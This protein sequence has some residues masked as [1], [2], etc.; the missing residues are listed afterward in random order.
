[1]TDIV[2]PFNLNSR[3]YKNFAKKMPGMPELSPFLVKIFNSQSLIKLKVFLMVLPIISFVLAGLLSTIHYFS[4]RYSQHIE[5]WH[6]E[7]LSF[8]SGLFITLIFLHLLP[9]F[10]KGIEFTGQKVFLL[11][12]I[13]FVSFHVLEKFLYQH[14]KNKKELLTNLAELHAIGFFLNHF[15]I[16]MV[17]FFVLSVSDLV[18]G[19]FIFIP[20]LLHTF[21][22]ALSLNHIFEHFH[23]KSLEI[24]LSLSPV[25]GMVF[26]HFLK[27][28]FYLFYGFFSL[29]LGAIIYIVIRDLMPYGKKGNLVFFLIGL[30]ISLTVLLL[31][32]NFSL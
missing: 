3:K 15:V 13:G 28:H 10:V 32:N 17:L 5:R 19:I 29:V 8:S 4:E 21:S 24:I 16:G 18:V 1:M 30:S 26:V 14:I 2:S 7:I 20:L 22:S 25:L 27:P 31:V 23:S 11:M 9:E 6:T 12:L